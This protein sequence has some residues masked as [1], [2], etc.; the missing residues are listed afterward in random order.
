MVVGS[1]YAISMIFPR[2]SR[3]GT[4]AGRQMSKDF[5]WYVPFRSVTGGARQH[6]HADMVI[7]CVARSHQDHDCDVRASLSGACMPLLES[8]GCMSFC[9]YTKNWL[10]ILFFIP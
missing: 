8:L 4:A 3:E 1:S 10:D 5:G 7:S 6:I 2:L 9:V